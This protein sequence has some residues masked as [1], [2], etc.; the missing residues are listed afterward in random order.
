MLL[1]F[2]Q[3]LCSISLKIFQYNWLIIALT[4]TM[5]PKRNDIVSPLQTGDVLRFFAV[6]V[7]C[8][9]DSCL[10]ETQKHCPDNNRSPL[11]TNSASRFLSCSYIRRAE[12]PFHC[13]STAAHATKSCIKYMLPLKEAPFI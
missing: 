8:G 9:Q 6:G 7:V 1:C 10:L 11:Q 4:L 5:K 3:I 13:S 2:V 12:F